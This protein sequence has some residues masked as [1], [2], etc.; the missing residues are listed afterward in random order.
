MREGYFM[1]RKWCEV[2]FVKLV[3][4]AYMWSMKRLVFKWMDNVLE[5]LERFFI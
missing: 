1:K 4:E 3:Y 5:V 2:R